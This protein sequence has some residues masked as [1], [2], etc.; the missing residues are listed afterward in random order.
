MKSRTQTAREKKI[1][2][3]ALKKS[4]GIATT[5]A[6]ACDVSVS[7]HYAWYNNDAEY[8]QQVDAL[9]EVTIDFAETALLKNVKKGKERSITFF[10]DRRGRG[11]GYG[12]TLDLTT[13]GDKI[14]EEL[15]LSKLSP[16]ELKELQA[17]HKKL[18]TK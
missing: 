2:L 13:K 17:I 5:A 18:R 1:F 11:R 4:L 10:L 7:N 12:K 9:A 16:K 14:G 15:D 8:K 3:K 6:I